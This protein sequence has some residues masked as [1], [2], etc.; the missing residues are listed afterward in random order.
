M[1]DSGASALHLGK[2]IDIP[3]ALRKVPGETVVCGNLDPVDIFLRGSPEKVELETESLLSAT[4]G[5]NNYV[6]SSGCDIPAHA[7]LVNIQAF[8]D[9]VNR[10]NR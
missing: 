1:L 10:R 7:P 4:D 2:M 8:F 9:S 5:F 6:I 3:E